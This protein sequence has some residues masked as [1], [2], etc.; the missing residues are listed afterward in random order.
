MSQE[1]KIL[2]SYFAADAQ[3]EADVIFRGLAA[4]FGVMSV[5]KGEEAIV[6]REFNIV[7]IVVGPKWLDLIGHSAVNTTRSTLASTVARQ[8]PVVLVLVNQA[9]LPSADRLP[10]GLEWLAGASAICLRQKSDAVGRYL[11]VVDNLCGVLDEMRVRRGCLAPE[12]DDTLA[13]AL[14]LIKKSRDLLKDDSSEEAIVK[15]LIAAIEGRRPAGQMAERMSQAKE[16]IGAFQAIRRVVETIKDL[17][18]CI[19]P[20]EHQAV[21]N[22][23]RNAE[24]LYPRVIDPV[25]AADGL[26]FDMPSA[27]PELQRLSRPDAGRRGH[28]RGCLPILVCRRILWDRSTPEMQGA[29]TA[30]R[31]SIPRYADWHCTFPVTF[32]AWSG[33]VGAAPSQFSQGT[34]WRGSDCRALHCRS[35]SCAQRC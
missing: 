27:R 6:T 34:R 21:G 3:W 30:A 20:E 13:N 7:V 12:D 16:L 26:P 2:I 8:V 19:H 22:M 14:E 28:A 5:F 10:A 29:F 18:D 17:P 33:R 1:Y 31:L 11:E 25:S 32:V 15:K 24:D 9:P 35:W 4:H 23:V